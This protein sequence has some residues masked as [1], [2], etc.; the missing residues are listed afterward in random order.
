MPKNDNQ[1]LRIL[2]TKQLLEEQTDSEHGLSVSD[3][4]EALERLGVS[5]DRKTVYD[6]LMRLEEYGMDIV[7]TGGGR[8]TDYRL[9][10]RDFEVAELKLLADAVQSA[11]FLSNS[12]SAALIKKLSSLTS[13]HEAKSLR[14]EIYMSDRLSTE[15]EQVYY[16]VDAIHDAMEEDVKISFLYFDYGINKEKVYRHGGAT[17]TVS[18]WGLIFSDGNYY[19]VAYDS[20]YGGMKHYRIDKMERTQLLKAHRD[21]REEGE[22][23][24]I[25]AYA[26]RM[27]GMFSGE[28]TLVTLRAE[29]RLS[30]V[31]MDRFGRDVTYFKTDDAHFELNV[32]VSVSPQFLGWIMSFGKALTIVGP[33]E[34]V[35]KY[36]SL[37]KEIL[38][39]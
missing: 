36:R 13:V 1:K 12:K 15:N 7:R 23:L 14:R 20:E 22:E 28:E 32:K 39:N 27:F 3:I 21:G 4:N 35:E 18:P 38:D 6:D 11:R 17:Y 19:M 25:S 9:V 10:S 8:S 33:H 34:V 31:M 29:N 24:D 16:A 30:G 2:Y 37:A 5:A 26:K